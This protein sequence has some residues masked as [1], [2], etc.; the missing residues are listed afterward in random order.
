MEHK[1]VNKTESQHT[2][3]SFGFSV[4]VSCLFQVTDP[5]SAVDSSKG[6]S[7]QACTPHPTLSTANIRETVKQTQITARDLK[8]SNAVPPR[9]IHLLSYDLCIRQVA[10]NGLVPRRPP[11]ILLNRCQP[12]GC[13]S[14]LLGFT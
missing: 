10:R 7:S 8:R 2:W 14:V 13:F 3:I 5:V 9:L 11:N 4:K 6:S 12:S 1:P